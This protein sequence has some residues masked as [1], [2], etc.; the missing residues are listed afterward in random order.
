MIVRRND[1]SKWRATLIVPQVRTAAPANS[2]GARKRRPM[3]SPAIAATK[4]A[5]TK[6]SSALLPISNRNLALL[7]GEDCRGKCEPL[8]GHHRAVL[9]Q[10]NGFAS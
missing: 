5:Q 1:Q 6:F 8:A 10:A 7:Q 3:T 4:L 9:R 2:A